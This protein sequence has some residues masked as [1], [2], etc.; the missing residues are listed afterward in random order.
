MRAV[1]AVLSFCTALASMASA[2]DSLCVR[3]IG[4]CALP[5]IAFDVDLRGDL[6]YV[7]DWL[8]GFYVISVHDP[9]VPVTLGYV[10]GQAWAVTVDGGYAYV[11]GSSGMRIISVADSAHP[12]EVGHYGG[13]GSAYGAAVA[14][15][16]AYVVTGDSGLRVVSIADPTNPVEV[17]YCIL[18]GSSYDVA[19]AGGYAYVAANDSGLRVVSLSDSVHPVEVG[20]YGTSGLTQ[21]LTLQGTCVYLAQLL[22][23]FR[24]LSIADPAHPTS[25][26]AFPGMEITGSAVVGDTVFLGAGTNLRVLSISDT[27]HPT[28]VGF[29][30]EAGSVIKAVAATRRYIYAACSGGLQVF[31]Y[32]LGVGDIDIDSDSLS[33]GSDTARLRVSDSTYALAAFVLANTSPSYNP[34][35]TDGP[36]A[37]PVDSISFTG[38]LTGPGGTLDSIF[39]RNLPASLAQGQT[40]ICTLAVYVPPGLRFG[41]YAGAIV[42]RGRD[43]WNYQVEETVYAKLAKLG[44]LDVDPDTLDAATDTIRVRPGR[45]SSGPPPVFTKYALGRFVLANTDSSYNPDTSDGPSQSPIESLRVTGSLS[46]PGGTLDSVLIP[47]LPRTLAQGQTVICTLAVYFPPGLKDGTYAGSITIDGRDTL[48]SPV[49]ETFYALMAKNLSDL[50]VDPD[51]LDVVHD[52]MNLAAQPAGPVYSPYAK[53]AFMLVNTFSGYNPDTTDGPSHS[54]LRE[55]QVEARMK[56]AKSAKVRTQAGEMDSVYVLNLPESLAVGQAIECTLA[57]TF[58]PH[59]PAGSYYGMV[60]ISASD[61]MGYDVQDSFYLAVRGPEPRG[62][63]ES[64]RVAPIP[65]KPNQNSEHDAIHFQGLSAGARV[66]VYDA[67]GQTV[68]TATENGDGYLKWDAN[69]ASGIYAYLVVSADGKSSKVG[70]LSVIR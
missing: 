37:S 18:P 58:P 27:A 35:T 54:A 26:G 69:V 9:A 33:V 32:Y 61:T 10:P 13:P 39:V 24:I 49:Q 52:T 12:V 62:N 66:T 50:D 70:K 3:R 38:S 42:F 20:Q 64:L 17:G 16:L 45:L 44:D 21:H 57:V 2:Q 23:S 40:V 8:D 30:R 51:S 6:A 1:I 25:V 41:S 29:W 34:D 15:N 60:V 36:S 65:F 28:E 48:G 46:G 11:S 67:S 55:L 53:A 4:H 43:A 68:W 7:A 59:A 31:Q 56:T 22:D 19:V 47:H 63:L 14:G 5:G